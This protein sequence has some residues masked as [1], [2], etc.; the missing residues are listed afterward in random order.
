MKGISDMKIMWVTNIVPP[1]YAQHDNI[2]SSL[3]GGWI[4][5][6]LDDIKNREDIELSIVFATRNQGKNIK[7]FKSGN[8]TYYSLPKKGLYYIKY[9]DSL[10]SYYKEVIE[11]I[12]PDIVHI[13][14]TETAISL[15]L[16]R[17]Y[18]DL[19]FVVSIQGLISII[20]KHICTLIPLKYQRNHTLGDL[21][22]QASP[23]SYSK[24]LEKA[25]ANEKEILTSVNQIIGRT[26]MD[27]AFTHQVNPNA[28]YYACNES[29]RDEFYKNNWD[30]DK[31]KRHT[32]LVSTAAAP[33]KG[34]HIM[35]HA[36]E[37]VR[38]EYPDVVLNI[39]GQDVTKS[40]GIKNKIKKTNYNRYIKHLIVEKGLERN[41]HF[42]GGLSAQEVCEELKNAHV[43]VLSS[44][45]ENSPNCLGEAMI[46]GTPCV[47]S[48]VAGVFDVLNHKHSGFIYQ[49]DQPFMLAHYICELFRNDDLAIKFSLNAQ[50]SAS[51]IH[52][53]NKNFEDLIRIYSNVI[54]NTE[55]KET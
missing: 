35:L 5:S 16:L 42:L 10:T 23:R 27:K 49:Y 34:V 45:M 26:T 53:K 28:K 22:F 40:K 4:I 51:L 41:I 14:G 15:N 17:E 11:I 6:I 3:S 47:A 44:V 39:I 1:E 9:D 8:I 31:C 32:I 52:D 37:I 55:M 24:K 25:S 21:I 29:L 38:S 43:F 36:L 33:V 50:Q 54:K 30:I 2:Q 18:K 20:A 7:K 19:E 13:H 12:K 46:V 48:A